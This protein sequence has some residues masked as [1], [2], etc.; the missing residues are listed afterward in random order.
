MLVRKEVLASNWDIEVHKP[1]YFDLCVLRYQ[2][3]HSV[4]GNE[5]TLCRIR[6][7]AHFNPEPLRYEE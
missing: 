2:L 3:P 7:K 5:E 4:F 6:A 1:K